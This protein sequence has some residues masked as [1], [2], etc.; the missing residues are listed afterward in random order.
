MEI[1]KKEVKQML[2][3]IGDARQHHAELCGGYPSDFEVV[4]DRLVLASLDPGKED[5]RAILE[6]MPL[7]KAVRLF[8]KAKKGVEDDLYEN[9]T[10]GMFEVGLT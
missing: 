8:R 1:T 5:H 3:A 6:I 10:E 4:G 2:Q 7:P 9:L